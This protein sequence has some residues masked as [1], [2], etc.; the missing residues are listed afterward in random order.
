MSADNQDR[1]HTITT[2]QINTCKTLTAC[3]FFLIFMIS[4]PNSYARCRPGKKLTIYANSFM[5]S[6]SNQA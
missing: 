1:L 3:S 2:D 5:L 4:L 6:S